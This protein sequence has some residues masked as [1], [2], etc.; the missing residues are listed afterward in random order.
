MKVLIVDDE[1]LEL[2][3]LEKMIHEISDSEVV[4]ANNGLE[5]MT[6]LS[7]G[8]IDLVF[9]DI[10]MPG[11]NGLEVLREI[12]MK[13]PNTIVSIIS[14]FDDFQYAQEAMELGATGYLLK[15]FTDEKFK[16]LYFKMKEER[17]EKSKLHAFIIQSIV[18]RSLFTENSLLQKNE[19]ES[20]GFVPE[21]MFMIRNE[22]EDMPIEIDLISEEV[23]TLPEQIDGGILVLTTEDSKSFVK[24]RLL[25]YNL[26]NSNTAL[27]GIGESPS[28]K[29]AYAQAQNDFQTRNNTVFTHFMD[30]VKS[31]YYKSL[32]LADVAKEVHVSA[33]HLNRLLKKEYDKTFT[34][35][36]MDFRINKSKK[37]LQKNYSVE[38]VSDLVGFNSASYFAVCFKKF[39]GVSPSRYNAKGG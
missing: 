20:I 12:Y 11:M 3:I 18:E 22:N 23:L 14:A 6:Y 29:I 31:N 26:A 35:I 36:L 17:D 34:E 8:Q 27:Y 15:P 33:S 9:L 13:W 1:P 7:S 25:T 10:K 38:V 16:S 5:A 30:Y 4:K 24:Q 2:A 37:L 21:V 32:S 19:I 28:L 39:T